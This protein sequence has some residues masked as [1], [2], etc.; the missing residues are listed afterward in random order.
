M[1]MDV[2]VSPEIASILRHP[3]TLD[4]LADPL[5]TEAGFLDFSL[6]RM[7]AKNAGELAFAVDE[8][9]EPDGLNYVQRLTH[10]PHPELRP[11]DVVVDIGCGPRGFFD[12]LDGHH[13]FLDDL[14][15]S[16][17]AK[18]GARYNGV[19]INCGTELLP[20]ADR[21]VDVVYSVNMIDH[22]EDM[23]QSMRELA[24]VL[25]PNGVIVLQ[26]YFNSH[27]LLP[28]EP[29]VFDRHFW[30]TEVLE[31]F[32]PEHVQTHC[33]ESP[34]ID[35]YY[36]MGV[37]TCHL[38]PKLDHRPPTIDRASYSARENLSVVSDVLASSDAVQARQRL[39]ELDR[40]GLMEFH[41]LLLDT[42][43]AIDSDEL[44]MAS[45]L[46]VACKSHP[47]AHRNP[48][49]R[50]A[51]MELEVRRLKAS[52]RQA[53]LRVQEV[54]SAIVAR[55]ARAVE[56]ASA[57]AQRDAR[58]GEMDAAVA[59]LEA[60]I[61]EMTSAVAQR[62]SR[63]GEL[64]TAVAQREA[65]IGELNTAVAQRDARIGELDSAVAGL[66]ARIGELD[67]AI[68]ARDA[69]IAVLDSAIVGRDAQLA[70]ARAKYV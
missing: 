41:G 48:Y 1:A 43:V 32:E 29:G 65:R 7:S 27:P 14:L 38:R 15:G 17:V 21:S 11:T 2:S 10:M 44:G 8:Y 36:T 22:V 28:T 9:T 3:V 63:I 40:S 47:R 60:R 19:P 26:T 46:L 54:T 25:R 45:E 12:G 62:D 4:V 68:A 6:D 49:A 33:V 59:G 24:R 61:G 5:P 67:S 55:D 50:V 31:W 18:L 42:L 23:A 69:R 66:R 52:A 39:A 30:D 35:R 51:I 34:T 16:Y 56:M 20:F 13:V 64:D 53:D 58:V 37:L 57:V 70:A